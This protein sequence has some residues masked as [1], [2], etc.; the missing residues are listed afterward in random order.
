M[1]SSLCF[2]HIQAT[3]LFTTQAL[4]LPG[5][6]CHSRFLR[7]KIKIEIIEM[8]QEGASDFQP[9]PVAW[10]PSEPLEPWLAVEARER[11]GGTKNNAFKPRFATVQKKQM[12]R[13]SQIAARITSRFNR[14]AGQ[15]LPLIFS[16]SEHPG[17]HQHRFLEAMR[18][19]HP[20]STPSRC[21]SPLKHALSQLK[22]HPQSGELLKE[23]SFGRRQPSRWLPRKPK[24]LTTRKLSRPL[25]CYLQQTTD[26]STSAPSDTIHQARCPVLASVRNWEL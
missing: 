14:Q 13:W 17:V 1:F 2:G 25:H 16:E 11:M 9:E 18:I 12:Y 3:E 5:L 26:T 22:Y 23:Q 10:S 15:H 24:Q 8:G 6:A 4:A 19:Q 21:N 7:A 20:K